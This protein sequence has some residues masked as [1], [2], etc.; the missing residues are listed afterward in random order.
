MTVVGNAVHGQV[1]GL[2]RGKVQ[3]A[4]SRG[5]VEAQPGPGLSIGDHV[6]VENGVANRKKYGLRPTFQV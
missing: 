6:S 3:V 5:I 4:T 1:I 2:V